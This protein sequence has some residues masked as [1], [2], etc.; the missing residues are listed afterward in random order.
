MK[1]ISPKQ[2]AYIE[3][4][5]YRDGASESDF[6]EEAGSGA[7]LVANDFVE[8]NDLDKQVLLLCGKGNNAGDAYVAGIHL[9]HL[10]Y[11]VSALQIIPIESCSS[12]CQANYHRFLQEGGWVFSSGAL[13]NITFPSSGIILDGIF[14]T[15]YHGSVEEPFASIIQAANRS[16]LPIIA[17]DIPSGLDGG[18]GEAAKATIRAVE[19]GFLGLPKTG[20]FLQDGWNFTGKLRYVDFGLGR[21]YIESAESRM[22]MLTKEIIRPFLPPIVRN[23]HKYERGLVVGLGGSRGMTGAPLMSSMAALQGGA[24]M[25]RLLHPIQIEHEM[26]TGPIELIKIP[27][28]YPKDLSLLTEH[29][30]KAS[31]VFIGPGLGRSASVKEML[32]NLLPS[33][34]KPCVIDADALTLLSEMDI[35]YP[36]HTVLTP[37]KGELLRLLHMDPPVSLDMDLLEK[38]QQFADS[39]RVTLVFKGAPTFIFH[40]D[41]PIWVNPTGD[42]GMATAGSGDVLT[43]LL[44]ALLAQKAP[45]LQAACLG[46]Y[47]HGLAG[48]YAARDLTSYCMTA[49]D[50]LYYFPEAFR[51]A[52]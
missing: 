13:E 44:A 20:F 3:S 51:L 15:G 26:S 17:V 21:E 16:R 24:G 45:P 42:P 41:E 32:E 27:F 37:H 9:L 35:P 29:L 6:M 25:V 38:C 52:D 34:E 40:P 18:T 48:E 43:G 28:E 31:A 46:V 19:T 39:K 1:I 5:A 23:R 49:S 11:K 8:N 12:L 10:D 4:L 50:I 33:L 14:G 22:I 2:M 30:N 36:Q 7:A 47:I